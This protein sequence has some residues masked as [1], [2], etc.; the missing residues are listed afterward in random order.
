MFFFHILF[1]LLSAKYIRFFRV[2][3]FDIIGLSSCFLERFSIS[4][5]A[6]V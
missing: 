3:L 2:G 1:C 5:Y 4:E 6:I